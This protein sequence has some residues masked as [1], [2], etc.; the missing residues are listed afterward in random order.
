MIQDTTQRVTLPAEI[1]SPSAKLVYFYLTTH[2]E[3]TIGELQ[4]CLGMKKITLYSILGTLRKR[5]LVEGETD[6]Y[7]ALRVAR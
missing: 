3:A 7:A 1:E 4:E 6:R 5:G 2:G